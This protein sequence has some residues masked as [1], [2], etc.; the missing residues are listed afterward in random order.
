MG[1]KV[2]SSYQ[3]LKMTCS[4]GKECIISEEVGGQN[5]LPRLNDGEQQQ[6]SLQ[7][8]RAEPVSLRTCCPELLRRRES[9]W[10][11]EKSSAAIHP[12]SKVPFVSCPWVT[13]G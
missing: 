3:N 13:L 9:H 10:S 12:K 6:P 2:G 7:I 1:V 8:P 11:E 4:K 5:C